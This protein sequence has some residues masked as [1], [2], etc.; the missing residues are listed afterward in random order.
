MSEPMSEEMR[1]AFSALLLSLY[2]QEQRSY[3]YLLA[4]GN[5]RAAF[6]TRRVSKR[7]K[8]LS[9]EIADGCEVNTRDIFAVTMW[10]CFLCRVARGEFEVTRD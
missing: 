8:R 9:D 1:G 2:E 3:R 5:R 10:E 4:C 6:W 7:I